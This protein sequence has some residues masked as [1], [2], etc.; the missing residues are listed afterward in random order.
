MATLRSGTSMHVG[1]V[2]IAILENV[3]WLVTGSQYQ[4]IV[5]PA[6][7]SQPVNVMTR[8]DKFHIG[9]IGKCP[10]I[11]S[12]SLRGTIHIRGGKHGDGQNGLG[13]CLSSIDQ[14]RRGDA[15]KINTAGR[16]TTTAICRT[17]SSTSSSTSMVAA[18]I[19]SRV[20]PLIIGLLLRHGMFKVGVEG[21]LIP[22]KLSKD[23]GVHRLERCVVFEKKMFL[24]QAGPLLAV[25]EHGIGDGNPGSIVGELEGEAIGTFEKNMINLIRILTH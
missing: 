19:H 18:V 10:S 14:L 7:H 11:R 13:E 17:S 4:L 12:T 5:R 24:E 1:W 16:T 23:H 8:V 3:P 2:S 25:Y 6:F 21:F 20:E 9:P 22:S 15:S